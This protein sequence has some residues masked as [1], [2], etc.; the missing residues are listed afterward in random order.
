MDDFLITKNRTILFRN[1]V[2]VYPAKPYVV[3]DVDRRDISLALLY[4]SGAA[5]NFCDSIDLFDFNVAGNND[6]RFH[7]L[8]ESKEPFCVGINCLY[9]GDFPEVRRLAKTIKENFPQ[10]K[11]VIGG[12]HPT[13]F[14]EEIMANC[15]AFDAVMMGKVDYAFPK[16]LQYFATSGESGL[17][18]SVV[19]RNSSGIIVNKKVTYIKNLD[20]LPRPG[21]EYINI[22]DYTINTQGWNDPR[23]IGVSALQIPLLTSRSCPNQCNFCAMRL[24]MG[25]QWRARSAQNVYAEIKFLYDN[26]GVNY[27]RIMDDNFTFNK[28]RVLELCN[29]IRRDHLKVYFETTNGLMMRTM[30]EELIAA[31]AESGFLTVSLA[32][33]SGSEFIRNK[34]MRKN[35]SDEKI[36][37]IVNLCKKQG[38]ALWLLFMIGMPEETETTLR[39]TKE[40]IMRLDV[41][42]ITL[43]RVVPFPGTKLFEQCL[44]DNLLINKILP[45]YLWTG[46]FASTS[47][48]DYYIKPYNLDVERLSE[49]GQ[50]LDILIKQKMASWMRKAILSKMKINAIN[51][52]IDVAVIS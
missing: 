11:I 8:M 29:W 52:L 36:D 33:E 26:Y 49:L 24:V 7:H 31:M 44:K 15:P 18:D 12:M 41:E 21:Y 27:F 51:K 10:V 43:N 39:Q 5:R 25:N 48:N 3:T 22:S 40:M 28:A 37:E 16:L 20:D 34:I 35:I 42:N 13:M 2:L 38:M 45:E 23:N 17:P 46:E 32:I 4:L 19:L 1:I 6:D 30:D 47:R 9:S 14:A 50:E